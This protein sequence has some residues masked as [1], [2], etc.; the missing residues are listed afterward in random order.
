MKDETYKNKLLDLL[1]SVGVTVDPKIEK[2]VRS[3]TVKK[4]NLNLDIA[5]PEEEIQNFRSAQG[6]IYFLQA[7]ELFTAKICK[8]CKETFLVS[9]K[10]IGFCSYTCIEKSLNEMGFDWV[11]GQD[12]EA[13]AQDPQVYNGNEPIWIRNLDKLKSIINNI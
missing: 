13:L 9:R 4:V 8:H 6:I 10:F 12:L 2:Q 11:K 7:P 3:T 1:G 5:V